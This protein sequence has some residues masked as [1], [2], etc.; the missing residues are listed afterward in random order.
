MKLKLIIINTNQH[1]ENH[2][3]GG[4]KSVIGGTRFPGKFDIQAARYPILIIAQG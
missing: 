1:E 2:N 4:H 3:S